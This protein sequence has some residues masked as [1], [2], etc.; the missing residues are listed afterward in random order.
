MP[1][2][3]PQPM[4]SVGQEVHGMKF[5]ELPFEQLYEIGEDLGSGQFAVVRRV[6][7]RATGEQYAAKYIKKRRY[8]TS[9][10]GVPRAHIEREVEMLRLVSGHDNVIDLH[11]VF[12]TPTDVI[13]VL[14]LVSGGELFDHVCANEYLNE[15][16]AASFIRQILYG[17]QHLHDRFVVHLDI[18]PENIMLKRRGEAQ[19]KLIDFGLSRRILPGATVKDMIGTPEFVAPEVVAFEPLS[20]ATDL[21]AIGVVVY[22]LLSGGSPFLGRTREE[23]FCNITAANYHFSPQYFG[24]VSDCAKDFIARLFVKSPAKRATVDDCLSHP[25][26][27]AITPGD[28]L[29]LNQR[30]AAILSLAQMQSLKL[31][32]K[33][34]KAIEAVR[35]CVRCTRAARQQWLIA[36]RKGLPTDSK[37]EP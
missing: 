3:T 16:E 30:T 21:W 15:P 19:I 36:M 14:E 2:C 23:T 22:V 13:L 34:K 5:S 10:R 25:W 28:G 8:A 4:T 18:K 33:W 26:I 24:R 9:R 1:E 31:R 29:D 12:E 7:K 6:T 35:M 20:T 27:R 32:L 37:F 11:E 17:V